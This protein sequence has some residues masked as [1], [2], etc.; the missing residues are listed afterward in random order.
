MK[1]VLISVSNKTGIEKLAKALKTAGYR[2]LSSGGTASYLMERAI[3]VEKVEDYTHSPELLSGRVKTLHPAIHAG[4]LAREDNETD[5][6]D[7]KRLG[8][9][10]IDILVC[11]LYPFEKTIAKEGATE[12]EIIENIDIGGVTLLRSSAKNYQ[13]VLTV[14]SPDDYDEVIKNIESGF[15]LKFKEKMAIKAFSLC[16]RYDVAISEWLNNHYEEREKESLALDKFVLMRDEKLLRYGEN[17][18]QEARSYR[19]GILEEGILSAKVLQGKELSYNNILDLDIAFRVASSFSSSAAVVVKHQCPTGIA[20]VDDEKEKKLAIRYAIKAD[21]VSAYGGILAFNKECD[22]EC[23]NEIEGLFLEC[24]V[25]PSF[26]KEA[27]ESLAK[28]K[29]CRV[30]SLP[31]PTLSKQNEIKSIV[32]GFLL[33]DMDMIKE[34]ELQNLHYVTKT[35]ADKSAVK[36]F[37]FAWK[38][39]QMIK[40]NA[41]V[42]VSELSEGCTGYYTCG[43]GGGQPNRVDAAR[44]AIR[45]AEGNTHGAVLASDAFIPFVDTIKEAYQAGITMII[46]PGG[47][48]RDEECIQFCDEHDISMV[49][50]GKRHFKH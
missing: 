49:F 25:A 20:E 47:S 27:L 2:I 5:I 11:N 43:I 34:E 31:F 38:A 33:Q 23:C 39:C 29:N 35:K 22:L 44:D 8:F 42:L 45:R 12:E 14:S 19:C 48:I 10:K 24:I 13:R 40:S 7:L 9:Y 15:S 4:L 41:I 6:A 18:H 26:S 28:R 50:V 46:Q 37:E 1:T 21:P 30:L 36:K 32:G 3:E 17:P 16:A